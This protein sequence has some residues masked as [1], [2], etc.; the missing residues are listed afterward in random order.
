MS[1]QSSVAQWLL[2]TA[3]R[4]NVWTRLDRDHP[5][6]VAWTSGNEVTPLV[7]GRSYLPE[8]L[9]CV[10]L[11]DR[12]DLLLFTDWRGDPDQLLDGP[13]SEVGRVLCEAAERGVLVKGF[14]VALASGSSGVPRA[15]EP[16]PG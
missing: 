6:Q 13:G 5:G 9:R 4:G 14:G 2:S 11:M 12:D 15:A 16:A 7:H 1:D 3:E 8:L 10:R